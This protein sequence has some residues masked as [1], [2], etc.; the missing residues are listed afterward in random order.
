[1]DCSVDN[2]FK[3]KELW[4]IFNMI[5]FFV[6]YI[7]LFIIPLFFPDFI[8]IL[9]IVLGF[10]AIFYIIL[11]KIVFK[12]MEKKSKNKGRRVLSGWM[13]QEM[14]LGEEYEIPI[15][16]IT[17]FNRL[18]EEDK[19]NCVPKQI[20]FVKF[21]DIKDYYRC[22]IE[23]SKKIILDN[24]PNFPFNKLILYSKEKI[25]QGINWIDNYDWLMDGFDTYIRLGPA[26]LGFIGKNLNNIPVYLVLH[27][28]GRN[29]DI[30]KIEKGEK[31]YNED[32]G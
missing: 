8:I 20:K 24:Y 28:P 30:F 1:M 26:N 32:R 9:F 27:A 5:F 22:V 2:R 7:S 31:I 25:D 18:S 12:R 11:K 17:P 21:S 13:D 3:G 4:K 19:K 29:T 16:K 14:D 10:L 6:V 23:T 15:K